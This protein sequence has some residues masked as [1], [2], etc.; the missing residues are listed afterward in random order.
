M[1]AVLA[2]RTGAAAATA[3]P[4]SLRASAK[5]EA[6]ERG[7]GALQPRG[8]ESTGCTVSL[9]P[10]RAA[11]EEIGSATCVGSRLEAAFRDKENDSIEGTGDA[12]SIALVCA[13]D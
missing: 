13:A 1:E 12:E 3:A 4:A 9:L 11:G 8:L 2:E 10:E 5:V 6:R 7:A